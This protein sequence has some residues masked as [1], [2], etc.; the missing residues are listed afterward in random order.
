[1]EICFAPDRRS[2]GL[3][4]VLSLFILPK[5]DISVMSHEADLMRFQNMRLAHD[6]GQIWDTYD[7][8]QHQILCSKYISFWWS[9][10][11]L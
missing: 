5:F 6:P 4:A 11:G 8:R 7:F 3:G 2:H 1:M 10:N 9:E